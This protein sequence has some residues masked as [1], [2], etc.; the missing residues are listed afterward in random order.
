MKRY[1]ITSVSHY[2]YSHPATHGYHMARL[3]PSRRADQ[4]LE[5]ADLSVE[6]PTSRHGVERDFFSNP[7]HWFS[8]DGPHEELVLTMRAQV[9][10]A[11]P[12]SLLVPSLDWQHVAGS[13]GGSTS[14]EPASPAHFL[15]PTLRTQAD[16][17]L[18]IFAARHFGPGTPVGQAVDTLNQT[19]KAELTYDSEATDVDTT[20]IDAFAK[21]AGVCQDFAHIMIA[22][23]RAMGVPARYVSGYIR[24]APPPGRPRLEG[25]DAMHAWVSVWMGPDSG[26]QD[27]DPTNGCAVGEDHITV[28]LGRDY[29]DTAPVRGE[30]V[31]SGEQSHT[32]AV[33]VLEL[34]S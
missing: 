14:L 4:R 11:R 1:T 9:Q 29:Q 7:V 34:A 3:V 27:Y 8:V 23:C 16:A 10:V 13:A 32:V 19:I 24:T 12:P 30:V 31:G 21:R 2:R 26:W 20:A 17:A 15:R 28:A 6:P 25:V 5:S 18:R 33:D 22:A